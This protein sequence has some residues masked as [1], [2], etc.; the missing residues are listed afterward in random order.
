MTSFTDYKISRNIITDNKNI[1]LIESANSWNTLHMN[2]NTLKKFIPLLQGSRRGLV[3][4]DAASTD[5]A[6]HMETYL[7]KRRID[8]LVI[9]T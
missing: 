4:L 6:S 7:S 3:V 9:P 2:I 1:Y 8:Q 5:H